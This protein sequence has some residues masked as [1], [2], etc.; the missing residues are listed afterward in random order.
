MKVVFAPRRRKADTKAPRMEYAWLV[1][2]IAV[3]AM[4]LER[5]G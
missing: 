5:D 3:M 2:R 1:R 4:Q